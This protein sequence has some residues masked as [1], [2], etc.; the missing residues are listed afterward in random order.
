MSNDIANAG[1]F[2]CCIKSRRSKIYEYFSVI[3]LH[4]LLKGVEHRHG[5][6]IIVYT[7][8]IVHFIIFS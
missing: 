6:G 1:D 3:F 2:Y 7:Y 8:E 5:S 4:A